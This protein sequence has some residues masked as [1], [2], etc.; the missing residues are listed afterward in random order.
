MPVKKGFLTPEQGKS[1]RLED[2]KTFSP[3]CTVS[4]RSPVGS[5]RRSR[6]DWKS[7]FF[8]DRSLCQTV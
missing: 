6:T 2:K 5:S 8:N 7:H 4:Y 3:V 1:H